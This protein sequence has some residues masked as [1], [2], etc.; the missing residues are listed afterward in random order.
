MN[1]KRWAKKVFKWRKRY[2][3]F[4]KETKRRMDKI[5]MKIIENRES[6]EIKINDEKVEGSEKKLVN[7][8]K[9]E[10]ENRGVKK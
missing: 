10:V 1:E 8:V 4:R 6:F 5:K 7:R 3:K 2:S 9:K